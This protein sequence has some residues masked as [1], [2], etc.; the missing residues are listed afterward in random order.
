MSITVNL[1][2][3]SKRENS[4]KVPSSAQISAGASFSCTLLD[5]TSLMN[6]TFKL[7]IESNPIGYNYCYVSNFNRYYFITDIS[8]HQNFWYVSCTCDVLASF[9]STIGSQTHYVLRSAS[10]SDGYLIDTLYPAKANEHI[11]KYIATNPLSW[12]NNTQHSYVLGI[13]GYAPTSSKQV[14]SVTYY[15]MDEDALNA[16]IYYLM[17]DVSVWSDISTAEYDPAV[18]EALLN[19]LQYVVSCKA[20]PIAPPSTSASTSIKFGYY[21]ATISGKIGTVLVN[22]VVTET[23]SFASIPHHPEASTRGKYLNGAPFS[24]YVLRCGPWGDIPLDP[25]VLLDRTGEGLTCSIRYDLIQGNGR[26]AVYPTT[27]PNMILYNGTAIVGVDINLTQV[28]RNPLDY[29]QSANNTGL[30]VLSGAFSL[31]SGNIGGFTSAV[32]SL[33]NGLADATRL[34]YPTVNSKGTNGSFLSFTDSDYAFYLIHKYYDVVEE[35]NTELGRP[36]CKA[37]QINTLS[38]YILCQGADC[39]ISGTQDEAQKINNYMN[40]GFFYE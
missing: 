39:Q 16:F 26:L 34:K 13:A 30:G 8:S 40:T 3:F 10:D 32:S 21:E 29:A 19:P 22:S 25:A 1:L 4:T 24:D 9:K 33:Y 27:Y 12:G 31:A 38:G 11:L 7:S 17:H 28:L 15:H 37:K 36:L 5:D 6:P 18:Q 35:N 20:F 23:T 14:G 2:S